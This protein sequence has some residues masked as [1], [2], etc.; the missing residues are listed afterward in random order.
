MP[1]YDYHCPANG[2]TIEVSHS[3]AESL[4]T[5]GDVCDRAGI[6]AG[7]TPPT[8]EVARPV[9]RTVGVL[10]G[11]GDSGMDAMPEGPCGPGGCPCFPG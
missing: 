10:A 11:A 9:N 2:R 6:D 1:R 3:M 4:T 8:A 7:D 5:W